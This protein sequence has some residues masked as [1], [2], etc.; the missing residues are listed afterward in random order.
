MLS[1]SGIVGRV[2]VPDPVVVLGVVI[3]PLSGRP[4]VFPLSEPA[5]ESVGDD[6]VGF[7]PRPDWFAGAGELCANAAVV[8]PAAMS[9][10]M[11]KLRSVIF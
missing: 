4:F 5:E 11:A 7:T 2:A 8:G 10:I 6:D 9:A 3:V 1:R